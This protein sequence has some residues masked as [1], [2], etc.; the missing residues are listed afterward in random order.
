MFWEGF[1]LGSVQSTPPAHKHGS[2]NE[3]TVLHLNYR[4][5]QRHKTGSLK[6]LLDQKFNCGFELMSLICNLYIQQ[7]SNSSSGSS[8]SFSVYFSVSSRPRHGPVRPRLCVV[9]LF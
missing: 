7:C 5:K 3:L 9:V 6:L 2:A 1:V 8:S 4:E